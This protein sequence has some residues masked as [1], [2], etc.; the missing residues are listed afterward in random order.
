ARLHIVLINSAG[1][2]PGEFVTVRFNL[3][4]GTSF[5][6]LNSFA[7]AGF[8]AKGLDSSTLSG[9]TGTVLSADASGNPAAGKQVKSQVVV[10]GTLPF[11]LTMMVDTPTKNSS[12]TIS[13]TVDRGLIPVINTSPAATVSNLTVAN[14]SWSA[15]ISGLVEGANIITCNATDPLTNETAS[16]SATIILDTMKPDLKVDAAVYGTK[17]YFK[18]IGG[19]VDDPP[20]H[21]VYMDVNCPSATVELVSVAVPN[22]SAM[23]KDYS[24]GDNVCTVTATDL[25][26][27]HSSKDVHIYYDDLAPDLVIYFDEYFKYGTSLNLYGT[28]ES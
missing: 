10:N 8:S 11:Y 2:S 27:N 24:H 6:A 12:Q 4:A 25:A 9:I 14:G 19:T 20:Y 17:S 26:G 28:V 22:W 3:K 16:V 15:L 18:V 5:P 7:I 23:I 1:F 13:G 21:I